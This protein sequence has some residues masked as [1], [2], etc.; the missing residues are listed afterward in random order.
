MN[1][2]NK[3]LLAGAL[4]G[5]AAVGDLVGTNVRNYARATDILTEDIVA[6][7]KDWTFEDQMLGRRGR[8]YNEMMG[9]NPEFRPG[10]KLALWLHRN[11]PM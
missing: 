10:Y 4:I 3:M 1:R 9:T 5:A 8:I 2:Y 11:G 6:V 7:R